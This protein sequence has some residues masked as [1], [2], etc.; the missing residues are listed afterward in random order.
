MDKDKPKRRLSRAETRALQIANVGLFAK[1][2]RR[3]AQKR[4]EP[5]DRRYNRELEEKLKRMRP[6]DLDRLLNDDG[7]E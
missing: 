5:N 4:R 7:E 6:A 1:E 2:Y 3:K